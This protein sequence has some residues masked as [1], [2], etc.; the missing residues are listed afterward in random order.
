MIYYSS[1]KNFQNYTGHWR[2]FYPYLLHLQHSNCQNWMYC[3]MT[4]QKS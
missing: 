3:Y 2:L 1:M 4:V